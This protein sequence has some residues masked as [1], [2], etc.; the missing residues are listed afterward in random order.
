MKLSRRRLI[1]SSLALGAMGGI[2]WLKPEDIGKDHSPYFQALSRTLSQADFTRPTLV[3][4]KARLQQNIQTLKA[5]IADHYAYR[6]VVKSLPSL[7]LLDLVARETGTNRFM[8]FDELF[9]LKLLQH[10][11]DSD[12]LLGKP[13]PAKGA[14]KI[15]TQLDQASGSRIRWLIDSAER[16]SEY[17]ALARQR[18]Q[19]LRI[20]LE[21][22]IGLHRGGIQS[23]DQLI[24]ALNI[25]RNEPL[26]SFDGFMGYEPH[27]VKIPGDASTHLASALKQYQ[28]FL[29]IAKSLLAD[30]FPKQPILNTAGSPSY[31]LHTALA[32]AG[33]MQSPCNELSAGS[34]L[35]KPADFDLP[36]LADHQAACFIASPV[37]KALPE[38]E[39]PGVAGLGK[40]MAWWNPN[41]KRSLFTYGGYWKAKPVS[42]EGLRYNPLYGR[43][44]NQEMLNASASVRLKMNDWVFLRPT[45]S[46]AVFLQFGAI[47][48]YDNKQI[49]ETWPVFSA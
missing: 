43:S 32:H 40:L 27:I 38:T 12:V 4:D 48:V 31:Q 17:Q 19:A 7:P 29:D 13:L 47:A 18:E 41:F 25:I 28:D 45:Q 14:Q 15:L 21:I 10:K 16:L 34:C 6:I 33:N 39:I 24:K 3:I 42:P 2:T 37:L 49:N 22:D 26:L 23:K 9:L 1:Q 8:L 5:R 30:S 46:E 36:S 44:S 11:P 35:V 20:N